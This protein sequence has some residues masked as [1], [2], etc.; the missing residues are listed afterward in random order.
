VRFCPGLSKVQATSNNV[1]FA[2]LQS[3]LT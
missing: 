2:S 1:H 3:N